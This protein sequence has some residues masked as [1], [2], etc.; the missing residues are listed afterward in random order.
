MTV[1]GLLDV[2]KVSISAEFKSFLLIMCIDALESTTNFLSSGLRFDGAGRHLFSEGEK[3]VALFFSFN[4]R[5]LL[6]SLHAV[7]R[8]HRSCHSVSSWDRSS[9][10]GAL[11]LRW[12]GS[13]GQ[14]IP[15]DGFWSGMSA[16]RTTAFVNFTHRIGFRM[17][18]LFR[19][20]DEEFGGST[21]WKTQPNCRV[22]GELHSTGPWPC[23]WRVSRQTTGCP[24]SI[25]QLILLQHGH[26]T[27]VIILFGPFDGLFINLSMCIRALLSKSATTLGLVE[28]AFWRVPL[29][30]EWIGASSFEVILAWPSRHSTTG[31]SSSG[32]SGSRR[33]HWLQWPGSTHRSGKRS[34]FLE[35]NGLL[36]ELS[37]PPDWFFFWSEYYGWFCSVLK[38]SPHRALQNLAFEF[39]LQSTKTLDH[40]LNQPSPL[41]WSTA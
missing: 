27:F 28:Q 25:M 6:G 38:Q 13:P 2:V 32:T 29:F 10:F 30:T 7:S 33:N 22:L 40:P 23:A 31:T 35:G 16:W 36:C 21:S 11:G 14:I 4:F 8:A 9:N 19:K 17:F 15:S 26:C 34:V 41:L 24:R 3:N 5:M 1:V 20:I 39:L 37:F 12:W 18:E